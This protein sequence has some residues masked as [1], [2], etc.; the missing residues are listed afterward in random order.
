MN[1]KKHITGYNLQYWLYCV[2]NKKFGSQVKMARD[3]LHSRYS[4]NRHCF[5]VKSKSI[6]VAQIQKF[7]NDTLLECHYQQDSK[8]ISPCMVKT[9]IRELG[10]EQ[11]YISFNPQTTI[12]G[13]ESRLSVSVHTYF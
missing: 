11:L 7:L 5:S 1:T 10:T 8:S 9:T 4:V 12:N 6:S 2:L 13:Q 3:S